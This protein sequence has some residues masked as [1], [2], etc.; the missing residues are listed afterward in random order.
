V[1][2]REDAR[3]L[4]AI[5]QPAHAWLSG[6]LA[7]AWGN[8]RFGAFEPFEE[9][10]LAAE[11]HD[12]GWGLVDLELAYNPDTHRPR[13]FMEMPLDVHLEIFR[14]GPWS[15]VSQ[16]RYAALLVS[17]H[18]ARLYGRRE[19]DRMPADEA[20]AVREFLAEQRSF[21]DELLA[22]LGADPG[23]ATVADPVGVERNSQ[24][25]WTW[26]YLSLAIC[27]GWDRATA[28]GAPTLQGTADVTIS[29]GPD[30]AQAHLDPWPF[31]AATVAVRAEGRRLPSHFENE[32]DM[33]AAVA[34]ARWETLEVRLERGEPHGPARAP[35]P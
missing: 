1:L 10:C 18:G 6:Q 35:S 31:A 14:R 9:V 19:L 2:I 5:G 23:T 11:Q 26:D 29:F 4:L 8:E 28:R 22:A 32:A 17:M 30:S 20:Q 7:Q 12:A 3:G 24:L 34:R 13:S 16:N 21:Q 15:L 33:R 25:V 27:L